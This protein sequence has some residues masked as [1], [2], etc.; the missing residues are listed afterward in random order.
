MSEQTISPMF[1]A[2]EWVEGSA[3]EYFEVENPVDETIVVRVAQAGVADVERAVDAAR[4]AQS[5]WAG[6][7]VQER[8]EIVR[9][10]G[11]LITADAERLARLVVAEVGKPLTEARG[12]VEGAA[13]Y[14]RFFAGIAPV[15]GGEIVP[16]TR[17]SNDILIR[18]EPIGVVAGIIP[19]NFPLA[20]TLRKV[21]PALVAG[22]AIVLKPSELTPL[23]ALAVAELA[24]RAGV[25]AGVLSVLPG[26][27]PT[28]GSA[29]VRAPEVGLVTMTGSVRAGRAIMRDAA[30][31]IIPV[32]LELGGKAPFIIF[33]DADLDAAVDAAVATRMMNNGQACVCNERTF[34]Q[35]GSFDEFV[36][37]YAA[38]LEALELGDP[39]RESTQ[40]G[41]KIS[42]PELENV[43][44]LVDEAVSRGATVIVGGAR[45]QGAL[46]GRGHWYLPTLLVDVP[47]DAAVLRE[48]IF[49]PVTPI[50]PFDGEGEAI[51]LAND[52]EY[53][54]SAYLYTEDYSR[55][56]RFTRALRSGE[57]FVNRGGPEEVGGFHSGWG[58]SGLGGDDGTHGFEIY[59]RRQTVYLSWGDR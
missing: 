8:A 4:R 38:R 35:R 47:R 44:R 13:G 49:G 41:P 28:V 42:R 34:V 52:S 40:V 11:D 54:L 24:V 5:G 39:T 48:E 53:G 58:A 32:S 2:G 10:L 3:G 20:L 33:D 19:W 12:E 15:Q 14:C 23:S 31:R 57:L 30:D 9:L 17:R 55:V 51:R 18:R 25:P 45:P 26:P 59:S 50:V 36:A 16:S 46:Y 27:G 6:R 1:L 29:L 37:K 56:M 43:E 7:T 21:A 22:N